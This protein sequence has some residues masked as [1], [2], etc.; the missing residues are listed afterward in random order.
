MALLAALPGCGSLYLAQAARGQ[1]QVMRERQPIDKVV[2]DK[3]TSA[4][5]RAR[6]T[7][8]TEARDFAS[9]ELGL[10]NNASYRSYADIKRPFVVWNVVATPEFSV[11][12]RKW[13]FPI[14]GCVAY[15]GYF[16]ENRARAFASS[17]KA[18]RFDVTVGG[19][20]A[21]STLGRIADPVLNTMLRYADAQLA[22][23]IF[24]ELSHQLVYVA[25]DTAFSEAFAVT[26]EQAG[27]ERWL[28]LRG[29]E[30]EL[31][32]YQ[33]QQVY[34]RETVALFLRRRAELKR[35]YASKIAPA[36]MR[37]RKQAVLVVLSRELLERERSSGGPPTIY[38]EWIA[39]GLNNAHLASVATY[40]NCV[41]GFERLLAE[42]G[43]DLQMFYLKARQ[44]AGRPRAERYARLCTRAH[45]EP[46]SYP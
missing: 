35:L 30:K 28:R 26:V 31:E 16:S 34:Q 19:I 27:L 24:H 38:S 42:E 15:R 40:F 8:V 37:K 45:S 3:A 9:R 17:L 6:L 18:K 5:L 25:G 7:E 2:E 13:C 32:Q 4:A 46:M 23:M 1:W 36:I 14:A 11:E 33:A 22:A 29:R 39:E 10:P 12:P 21:Y 20:P 41:P 43:G 44:L